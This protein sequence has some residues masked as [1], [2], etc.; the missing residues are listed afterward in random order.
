MINVLRNNTGNIRQNAQSN[1][2][3]GWANDL[4]AGWQLA[5]VHTMARLWGSWFSAKQK[6]RAFALGSTLPIG[7]FWATPT[8]G[9]QSD[10][11]FAEN[12]SGRPDLNRGPLAPHAS[13]LAKLRHAPLTDVLMVA[14][15]RGNVKIR[16]EA[17]IFQPCQMPLPAV[18]F[19]AL[20]HPKS[21]VFVGMAF[22]SLARRPSLPAGNPR[23]R[24]H[25]HT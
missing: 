11:D 4:S 12:Q 18:V 3:Y 7:Y 17:L 8:L 25:F 10:P 16:F 15:E 5:E 19:S 21:F 14:I 24:R 2:C 20:A 23:E 1:G 9:V 13:A 22:R 6:P